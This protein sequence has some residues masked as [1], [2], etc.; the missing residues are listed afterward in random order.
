M[1]NCCGTQ[2]KQTK[3]EYQLKSTEGQNPAGQALGG[4]TLSG[5]SSREAMLLAA[6]K[7]KAEAE[8]RG[9]LKG[10][11]LSKKLAEEQTKKQEYA[12]KN[13]DTLVWD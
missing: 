6:E 4:S 13:D 2:R 10:G 12:P 9:V 8:N 3:E 11:K 1:G 5:A 7:R